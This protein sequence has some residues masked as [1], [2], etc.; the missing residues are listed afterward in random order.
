MQNEINGTS[1]VVLIDVTG[2][3][4]YKLIVCLRSNS[5]ITSIT[6]LDASAKC[7][8][9]GKWIAGSKIDQTVTGEGNVID[10]DTGVPTNNGF[11]ELY[12]ALINGTV[13]GIKF[14]KVTPTTGDAIYT[15][16]AIITKLDEVAPYD[17]I[18]TFTFTA[19]SVAPPFTQTITY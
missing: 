2:G 11:P 14:G 13:V 3:T 10:P 9:A 7:N 4:T 6:E 5:M 15:G 18:T 12:S 1:I 16:T 17:G 19:R 8:P